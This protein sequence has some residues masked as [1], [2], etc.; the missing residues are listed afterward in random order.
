[1][2]DA[3]AP[4]I[5]GYT[6]LQRFFLANAQTFCANLSP[7][8]AP[9]RALTDTHAPNRWRVNG[10]VSS[11]PELAAAFECPASS[12]MVRASRCRIW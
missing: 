6:P 8:E 11:F 4:R 12:A 9:R 5:D 1:M 2:I 3:G 10:V 7:E